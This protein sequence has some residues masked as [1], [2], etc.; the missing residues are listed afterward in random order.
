LSLLNQKYYGAGCIIELKSPEF[1]SALGNLMNINE[2]ENNRF[3]VVSRKN[4]EAAFAVSPTFRKLQPYFEEAQKG[5]HLP[6]SFY[7]WVLRD[8]VEKSGNSDTLPEALEFYRKVGEEIH[9]ACE[10]GKISCL[11]RKSSIKPLWKAKY[12]QLIPETF[13]DIFTMG[14]SFRNFTTTHGDFLRTTTAPSKMIR[15]Y[16]F[17]TREKLAPGHRYKIEGYPEYFKMLMEEKFRILVDIGNSYKKVI[18]FLFSIALL[19]HCIIIGRSIKKREIDFVSAYG[20]I[21][22]VGMLS[23]TSVLTYVKITLWGVTRPLIA[24]YPLVLLYISL[25]FIFAC[26]FIKKRRNF[27][28]RR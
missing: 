1:Q 24:I 7:I 28:K 21:V 16:R 22:L 5:P 9:D 6:Q 11:D 18:P 25:M 27:W 15:D 19:I 8:M 12:V 3:V 20:L 26:A 17:V 4:Q 10:A 14:I 2:V 13:W 23:L